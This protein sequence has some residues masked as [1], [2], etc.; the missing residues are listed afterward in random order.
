MWHWK[1]YLGQV[2]A[3]YYQLVNVGSVRMSHYP[4]TADERNITYLMLRY[5]EDVGIP[6]YATCHDCRYF[7][8]DEEIGDYGQRYGC[9]LGCKQHGGIGG[10]YSD[11]EDFPFQP[12]PKE[13]FVIDFWKSAYDHL[14]DPSGCEQS[15]FGNPERNLKRA[16]VQYYTRY[17]AKFYERDGKTVFE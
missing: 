3:I 4:V 11:K 12:A 13:C 5:L 15:I 9:E 1:S 8:V 2:M 16:M 17:P 10:E 14:I 6:A 7:E